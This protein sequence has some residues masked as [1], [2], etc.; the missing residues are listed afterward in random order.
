MAGVFKDPA[1]FLAAVNHIQAVRVKL[2]GAT[3]ICLV[4]KICLLRNSGVGL[5]S[6]V[7]EA[8]HE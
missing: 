8:L 1:L 4:K 6:Y 7:D 5:E 3:Q 2:L